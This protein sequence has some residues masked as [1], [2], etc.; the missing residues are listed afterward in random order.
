MG[1]K[2]PVYTDNMKSRK[3]KK[4]GI[5]LGS[6][7]ARGFAHI[8]VLKALDRAG[9]RIEYV[10]GTSIG[11][12]I[13]AYY[14]A[15][16][17]IGKLEALAMDSSNFR[18]GMFLTDPFFKSGL[19]RG[20]KV[21]LFLESLFPG[22]SFS[23]LKI[24]LSVVATDL[25]EGTE[26]VFSSGDLVKA[27]RASIS[28]PMFF[29]PVD[30][31]GRLMVDGGIVN[32]VPD[33][34]VAG[35]GADLVIAVNLDCYSSL[36]SFDRKNLSIR[37]VALRSFQIIRHHLASYSLNKKDIL[38]EPYVNDYGIV[39]WKNFFNKEDVK[40]LI[41]AGELATIETLKIHKDILG[42]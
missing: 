40:R 32:P 29:E 7:G 9:I 26:V 20:K 10:S 24:P 28:V 38:I 27:L 30:Y 21:E 41:R 25:N 37:K 34:V 36:E 5:A 2:C 14:S 13:G 11:A 16:M 22:M 19:L 18:T 17:D 3:K 15:Y 31:Q 1:Q 35:M 4:I 39:G 42:K 12:L 23:D 33:D 6:G 8:G